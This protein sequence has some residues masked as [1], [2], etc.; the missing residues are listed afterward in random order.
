MAVVNP[1]HIEALKV[2]VLRHNDATLKELAVLLE[3][4]T[5]LKVSPSTICRQLQKLG[6]TL[7]KNSPSSQTSI[8]RS[9]SREAG[10]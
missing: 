9:S 3:Q 10:L 8:S 1:T 4:E 2:I 6:L 7:K 5:G